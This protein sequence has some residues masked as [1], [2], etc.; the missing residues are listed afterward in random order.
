MCSFKFNV[1]VWKII[2]NVSVPRGKMEHWFDTDQRLDQTNET[3]TNSF[4]ASASVSKTSVLSS[5]FI[6]L[7]SMSCVL[8]FEN[9]NF[10]KMLLNIAEY[11]TLEC[12]CWSI[13]WI[14]VSKFNI[15]ELNWLKGTRF[16]N[17]QPD[18]LILFTLYRC[19]YCMYFKLQAVQ[20][21]FVLILSSCVKN[22]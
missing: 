7:E 17:H 18:T 14:F 1:Y 9:G 5:Y 11:L 15:K 20:Y 8:W 2:N 22:I 12:W 16:S 6:Q 13:S 3:K 10:I 19:L 4:S 21:I